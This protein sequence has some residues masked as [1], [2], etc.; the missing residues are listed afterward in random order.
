[1]DDKAS[2]TLQCEQVQLELAGIAGMVN[3][4]MNV[5]NL[6]TRIDIFFYIDKS[7]QARELCSRLQLQSDDQVKRQ[8]T[9]LHEQV[10]IRWQ[11]DQKALVAEPNIVL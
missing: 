2:S 1:M 6:Y 9:E 10:K 8:L 5:D 3:R 11:K 4:K 7:I